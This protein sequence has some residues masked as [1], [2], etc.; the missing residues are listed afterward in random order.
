[1]SESA[2]GDVYQPWKM[3]QRGEV[4]EALAIFRDQYSA[5]LGPRR[6]R[7]LGE[8]LLWAGDCSASAVHF[9]D[10]ISRTESHQGYNASNEEDFAFLGAAEWCSG[11]YEAAIKAWGSGI[12]AIYSIGGTRTHCPLLLLLASTLR[13]DLHRRERAEKI[14][15]KRLN[16][17]IAKGWPASEARYAAGLIDEKELEA[18]WPVT[19]PMNIRLLG[20]EA[21]W[22]RDFYRAVRNLAAGATTMDNARQTWR[23]LSEPSQY[24]SGEV[25]DFYSIISIP[26]FF[27]ARHESTR[28]PE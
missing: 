7:G 14:L 17:R 24:E 18:S 27:I 22:K 2:S 23:S 15:F 8:A 25:K 10:A 19:P 20:P 3:L 9:R 5:T 6:K 4:A 13:P 16:T 12:K 26:E 11:D 21:E 1:M 28:A